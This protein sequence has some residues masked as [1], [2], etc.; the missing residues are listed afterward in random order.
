VRAVVRVWVRERERHV[1]PSTST[2]RIELEV[3]LCSSWQP[4]LVQRLAFESIPTPFHIFKQSTRTHVQV[5][6]P[7]EL[8]L[9]A[10]ASQR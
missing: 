7:I 3:D 10:K 4:C 9:H 5:N 6:L 8:H 1:T 2:S